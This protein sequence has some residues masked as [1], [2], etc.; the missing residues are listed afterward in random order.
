MAFAQ[1]ALR[2][3]DTVDVTLT[4]D[5]KLC[6]HPHPLR[7]LRLFELN[8]V[9]CLDTLDVVCVRGTFLRADQTSF[10][11]FNLLVERHDARLQTN[12]VVVTHLDITTQ[13][14]SKVERKHMIKYE[15]CK[16]RTETSIIT[17][18]RKNVNTSCVTSGASTHVFVL[19]TE[20]RKSIDSRERNECAVR[21][22][23]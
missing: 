12:V 23:H 16:Q 19:N 8:P 6:M 9:L 2:N 1:N 10:Q 4:D 7:A 5:N 20:M 18:R 14:H 15:S 13:L 22:D 17:T 3:A 11:Q 21:H